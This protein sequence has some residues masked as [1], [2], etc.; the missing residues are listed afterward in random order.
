LLLASML[1]ACHQA[2]PVSHAEPKFFRDLP[3]GTDAQW[4]PLSVI[5][6]HGFDQLRTSPRSDF[7][8]FPYGASFSAVMRSVARPDKP[9]KRYGVGNWLRDEV[10]PLSLKKNGG[11][12]WYPNYTLHLFGSGITYSRLTDWYAIE[13]VA[14]PRL[15]A[16]LT[17]YAY[18]LLVETNE[19][20][21]TADKGVDALTDLLIFDSASILLWNQSWVRSLFGQR[22]EVNDWL[23]QAS[24]GVP[25]R[26][27]ENASAMVVLRAPVPRTDDWRL[28][29]THGYAFML[30]ASRR[31]GG[32]GWITLGGGADA[33]ANP[34]IDSTTGKKTATLEP[35]GGLFYDRNGSLI[36]SLI[37]RGGSNNGVTLNVYPTFGVG[38]LKPGLWLQ[39]NKG[40]GWR[41][42]ISS[43]LGVGLSTHAGIR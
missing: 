33:P 2:P 5:V 1:G 43:Q 14:H 17:T 22:L 27:I 29:V 25:G 35:N 39:Q 6:N 15:A 37:T 34:V 19:N 31:V 23:G 32:D 41:F 18:H 11:G 4:N 28:M 24:L 13:G 8:R 42:G 38:T 40:G 26:T 9:I 21:P 7:T 16:G 30:G 20:G 10:F 3:Y 12:Q 36:A